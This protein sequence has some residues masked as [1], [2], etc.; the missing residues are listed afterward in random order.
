MAR[1]DWKQVGDDFVNQCTR[2]IDQ[3][4][5]ATVEPT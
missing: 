5:A 1:Y 4:T 2:L 3:Q